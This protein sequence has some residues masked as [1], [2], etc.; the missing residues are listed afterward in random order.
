MSKL[1][2]GVNDLKTL[3]PELAMEWDAE[4][5]T[6]RNP[7]DVMPGSGIRVWW[8]CKE[9]HSWDAIINTR[10][11]RGNGCPYCEGRKAWPGFKLQC[12][13]LLHSGIMKGTG[14]LNRR[15]SLADVI[16]EYGGN[17]AGGTVGKL[18]CITE[19]QDMGVLSVKHFQQI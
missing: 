17:V 13:K 9:G 5:N 12:R 3:N 4:K 18:L 7:E 11:V 16:K 10:A 15:K 8:K 1:I 2:K 14:I 19:S 6:D